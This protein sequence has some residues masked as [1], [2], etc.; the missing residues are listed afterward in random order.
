MNLQC[1]AELAS[2]YKSGSQVARVLTEEWCAREVYCPACT[3]DR[4]S[5]SKVNAPAIDFVCP[6]CR[7]LFQ[8]KSIRNWNPKKIVDAGYESMLRSIRAD[9]V[10]NL[11]VLQYSAD[12]FV[13]NLLLVP[14]F[15]FSES[16]IE[17][18]KPLTPQARR[19]GWVG[20]NILL[21]QI[22]TDGK[23]AMVSA[24]LSLPQRQVRGEFA[25]T[26]SLAK[27]PPSVR[28]WTLDVLNVA[29]RLG[30]TQFTLEDIYKF[31]N[32]L[33]ASHPDNH[34]VRPKIRQQ[35]QVLRDLGLADFIARG[36]YTLRD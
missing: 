10:P 32:E 24:G 23:I 13:R 5:P 29:R 1:R 31:E 34:N 35:L 16:A 6:E 30:K 28:G 26:R 11:L 36:E 19:A 4:L 33:R 15:F 12:W 17:K 21:R 3:S 2:A 8:L 7:Q 25:R 27:V 20:C 9:K 22:P 14:R 18:R